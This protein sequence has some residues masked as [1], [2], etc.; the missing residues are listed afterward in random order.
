MY[1]KINLMIGLQ[2][3]RQ[4]LELNMSVYKK[5]N[6]KWYYQFMLNGERKHGICPGASDKKEAEQYENSIKFR[7]AQQQN[8]VMPREEKCVPLYKLRE[9]YE[10]YA[11]NNKK[12]YK[13]DM[14]TL[15]V[16]LFYF[17]ANAI[18][19]HITPTQIEKFK[20]WLKTEREVKNSTINHYLVLLSKMFN[21]GIDNAIIRNNPIQKV[22]KLREDNHKIRYLTKAEES[23]LFDEIEREY[24]V[25]DKYTKKAKIVQPYLYLKPIIITALH[26]GMRRGEILNL[27]WSNIDFVQGFIELLET[28]SGKS[29]KIPI[30]DSLHRVLK[31]IKPT[32]EYV[33]INPQTNEPYKDLK[34][35]FHTV[36]E[37]AGIK[38]FRFHDLRHTVATR[39]VEK[40]IDLTVVQEILGHSKITTTQRYAHP[41]PQRKLDA[42]SILNDY[43]DI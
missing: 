11:K 23:R 16:I 31:S 41:V 34:K 14:Y 39:L 25:L 38:N 26:T 7:L 24:E 43:L 3:D 22:S 30:S 17:G 5:K 36:L 20:E 35:S 40:G 8:G 32:S 10:I 37:K 27:K 1:W 21:V 15:Q 29:R 42:I 28:K 6:N 2:N 12:S 33:F 18:V 19:Q 9:V 13:S 4:R